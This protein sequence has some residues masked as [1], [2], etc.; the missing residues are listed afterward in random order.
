[1]MKGGEKGKVSEWK[2][3]EEVFRAYFHGKIDK[4]GDSVP[5]E[6]IK[7]KPG[8]QWNEVCNDQ[9]FG[10]VL[11]D[12]FIDISFDSKELSDAF[13]N[14][15]DENDWKCLILENPTNGHIH[16]FWRIPKDWQS[17]D[18]RDKKLSVGLV[19]DI[20]SGS[21]YIRLKANGI[22]RFPPTHEPDHIQE[23]PKELYPV[24]SNAEP[25]GMSEGGRNETLSRMVKNLIHNTRFTKEQIKRILTNTNKFVFGEPLSDSELEVILRD[26]TFSDMQER[27]L[28]TMNAAELFSTDIK[29]TEFIIN[30]LIPV[31][32][33]LVA[34]PPKYGKSWMMLDMSISVA[35][36]T[37]FLGFTTNKCNVLYLA[38]EDR[39]DRL[40][41]RMLKITSGKVFPAGLEIAIDAPAL[42]DGFI[43]HME[44]F[45]NAHPENKLIIIDT[46]VKIRG[47]PNGKE[48]AYALDSRE[49]GILKKFADQHD[50]AIVLVTH[51]RKSIDASDPVSNITGTFGVAG[52]ADDMIIL[53]K[54]KRSD[55]L[56]KMSVTGRDVAYEEYPIVFD[57][58]SYKWVRQG[59]SFELAAARQERELQFAEYLTGNIRKT[60]LKLLEENEGTWQGRCNEILD[61]SREYGTPIDLT[62]K[63]LGN[64]LTRINEFLYNDKILHTEISKGTASKIHKYEKV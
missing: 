8:Y 26:E 22:D 12:G 36:G 63:M 17:K 58:N 50:V 14:M 56:T 49:A 5:A 35:E 20:H 16:S 44:D 1:M 28:N 23:V 2:G 9:N 19:A 43:E 46:F 31:G 62:S 30:G 24:N 7:D 40:K 29:P 37:P 32:L 41:D 6:R 47:I 51:T 4:N 54:E 27:K 11:N 53:T 57:Q 60:L 38:L 39:Y 3:N 59:E 10:T 45:L 34:S 33:S 42:G 64:E 25:F 48:A 52:A 13:W 61:K 55:A 18:G 21:T 15:A